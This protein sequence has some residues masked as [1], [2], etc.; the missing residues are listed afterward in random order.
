MLNMMERRIDG[1]HLQ[2]VEYRNVIKCKIN[3]RYKLNKVW[4][5]PSVTISKDKAA[6]CITSMYILMGSKKKP[7]TFVDL[8]SISRYLV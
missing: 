1:L 3:C 5:C 6:F 2:V 4:S 7:V 8:S